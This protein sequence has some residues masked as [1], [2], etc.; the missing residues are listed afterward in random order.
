MCIRILSI[1]TFLVLAFIGLDISRSYGEQKCGFIGNDPVTFKCAKVIRV[2]D[3]DT[4]TVDL[5]G[6]PKFFG[7]D[8][9]VRVFGINSAEVHSK[10]ACEKEKGLKAKA[11][12]E[13]LLL[14]KLVTLQNLTKDKYGRMLADVVIDE[15]VDYAEVMIG[16][17]L[18]MPYFGEKKPLVNW[19]KK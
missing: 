11:E 2:L 15:K 12:A 4:F 13:K 14:G 17:G 5:Q 6:V 7:D 16:K 10:D 1:P 9:P 3:G 8:Q 19:C 18:A